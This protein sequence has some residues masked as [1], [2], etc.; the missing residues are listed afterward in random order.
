MCIFTHMHTQHTHTQH[1]Q[2]RE[3]DRYA[4]LSNC[5]LPRPE[6]GASLNEDRM[7]RMDAL[8]QFE[9]CT[10]SLPL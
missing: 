1:K 5:I 7:Q 4:N 2:E 9:V 10:M 6:G 3:S 8:Q